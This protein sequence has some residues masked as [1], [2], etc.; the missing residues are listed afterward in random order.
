MTVTIQHYPITIW[1]YPPGLVS[2]KSDT[3]LLMGRWERWGGGQLA[4][5][6]RPQDS[7]HNAAYKYL[8]L[9]IYYWLAWVT[10][11]G[12]ITPAWC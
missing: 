7:V 2:V 9:D 8:S 4:E 10:N 5:L 12:S 6:T 1:H 11:N 3:Y